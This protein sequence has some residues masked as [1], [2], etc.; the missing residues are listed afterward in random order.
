MRDPVH[1]MQKEA[2]HLMYLCCSKTSSS[3]L[4]RETLSNMSDFFI[5]RNC[6]LSLASQPE[7]AADIH[8]GELKA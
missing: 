4:Q 6:L 7:S 1:I 2:Q 5:S 3:L 8:I